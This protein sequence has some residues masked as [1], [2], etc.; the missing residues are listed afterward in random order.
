MD[1]LTKRTAFLTLLLLCFALTA[2]AQNYYDGSIKLE[3]FRQVSKFK[4]KINNANPD[5]AALNACIFFATNEQRQKFGKKLLPYNIGLEAAAWY[6]SKHMVEK[7]FF[8]HDNPKEINRKTTS[9]RAKLA[10]ISNASIAEN[11]AAMSL[12]SATYLSL[13]DDFIKM[14]MKSLGHKDNILSS[15]A[16]AMGCGVFIKEGYAK[17][18]QVFQWF[19]DPIYNADAAT[20]KLSF[21]ISPQTQVSSTQPPVKPTQNT[22]AKEGFNIGDRAPS[23]SQTAADGSLMSLEMV[24]GKVT[25]IDFWASWCGPCRYENRNLIQTYAHFEDKGFTVFSVSLDQNKAAW[26]KAIKDD[27]LEWNYHVSD[28]RGWSNAMG[29]KYRINSIPMNYLINEN[30]IIIGKNLRGR[31]LDDAL[32]KYYGGK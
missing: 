15:Q 13:A 18:T 16:T 23:I 27:K 25:L 3:G 28:L 1:L 22:T 8:D 32:N 21:Q 31:A 6:H 12:S 7:D 29:V 9:D 11:I 17:A 4:E 30:G 24:K 10:G 20:D 26:L 5:Y 14:W 19:R 2:Y